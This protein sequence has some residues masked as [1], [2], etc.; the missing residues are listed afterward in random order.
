MNEKKNECRCHARIVHSIA[1]MFFLFLRLPWPLA[2][3]V[4]HRGRSRPHRG[5]LTQRGLYYWFD[6][7][8][9]KEIRERERSASALRCI[10]Y[11]PI[12]S[13]ASSMMSLVN[14][15]KIQFWIFSACVLTSLSNALDFELTDYKCDKSL[16][17]QVDFTVRC[18]GGHRCTFGQDTAT[19]TGFGAFLFLVLLLRKILFIYGIRPTPRFSNSTA[20]VFTW[21][22]AHPPCRHYHTI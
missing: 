5:P 8:Y 20:G 22:P 1:F 3:A 21:L 6:V 18:N 9:F 17:V 10:G 15:K 14:P 19:I 4:N 12:I 13:T 7:L 16:Y 11:W 2:I